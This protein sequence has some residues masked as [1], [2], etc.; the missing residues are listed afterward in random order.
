[1][2]TVPVESSVAEHLCGR[3]PHR[4]IDVTGK[5]AFELRTDDGV[6]PFGAVQQYQWMLTWRS[7]GEVSHQFL[8]AK[9]LA[10]PSIA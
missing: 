2:G 5:V 7:I 1:M 6:L 10:L 3:R 8:R 4:I 9:P